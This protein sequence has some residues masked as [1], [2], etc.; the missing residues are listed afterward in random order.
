MYF[1]EFRIKFVHCA[2]R[3]SGN[4]LLPSLATCYEVYRGCIVFAFS[5]MFACLCVNFVS[6]QRFP[7]NYLT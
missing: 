5:V 4:G 2:N 1:L 6:G 7:R 3:S